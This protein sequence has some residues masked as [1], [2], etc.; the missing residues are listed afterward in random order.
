MLLAWLGIEAIAAPLDRNTKPLK[1]EPDS[2]TVT[3]SPGAAALGALKAV[4]TAEAEPWP[5]REHE[6][7]C[8]RKRGERLPV[9]RELTQPG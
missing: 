6:A 9:K 5:G 8:A 4:D 7:A 2:V 1:A 3:V